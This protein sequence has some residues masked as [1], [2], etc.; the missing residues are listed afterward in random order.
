MMDDGFVLTDGVDTIYAE[1]TGDYARS[2]VGHLNEGDRVRTQL[3]T[4]VRDW[5]DQQGRS[6]NMCQGGETRRMLMPIA[7]CRSGLQ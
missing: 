3:S 4:G 7:T 1:A 5:Q 6:G 2:L